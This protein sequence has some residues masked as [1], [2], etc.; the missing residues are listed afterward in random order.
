MTRLRPTTRR[1]FSLPDEDRRTF[2]VNAAFVAIIVALLVVLAGVFAWTYYE[3]NLR[4]VASVGGVEI[5]PDMVVDRQQLAQRRIDRER[6]RLRQAVVAGEIDQATHDL[7]RDQLEAELNELGASAEEN[8]IDLIFQSQLASER[9]ISVNEEDVDARQ[10]E[11]LAGVE[12]RRVQM[13]VIEPEAAEEGSPTYREREQARLRAAEALAALEAGATFAE[14][15]QEYGTDQSA[16]PDGELG[17]VSS[18]NQLDDAFREELFELEQGELTGVVRGTDDAYRIGRVTEIIA[19][20][21]E[22]SFLDQVLQDMPLERYRQFLRWEEIAERLREDVN[23]ELLGGQIEQL[24]LSHIRIDASEAAD[25]EDDGGE[26]HYSEILIAPNGNPDGAIDLEEDDP[27]WD[28]ARE[29]AEDILVEL[30]AITDPEQRATRFAELA[31]AESDSISAEDGGDVGFVG[32]ELLPEEVGN[33][34]FD[35]Q[36]ERGDLLGPVR[37]ETGYYV[38]LFH[39]RRPP[40]AERLAALEAAIEQPNPDWPVLVEEFS[41]DEQSRAEDGDIGWWTRTMLDQVDAELADRLY[42][43]TQGEISEPVELGNSTHVFFIAEKTQRDLDADQLWFLRSD[44][45]AF[46]QWYGEK[47]E[48]AE[49]SGV[50]VRVDVD[51]DPGIDFPDEELPADEV[52]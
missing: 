29:E 12:R 41:D 31:T 47:K 46:E 38:M 16:A 6:A 35:E 7:R 2:L 34:L 11:Q 33:A 49:A 22:Q 20:G 24:R 39:Q 10:A 26:V 45:D 42:G 25:E 3:Q 9:G 43:L 52:P 21:P 1:R 27:A 28:A 37:D 19:G 48:A 36:H 30:E 44:N 14:V 50:I 5:R 32:R 51:D 15:A 18:F 8:L 23:E 40:A 4:P 17:V 13:V